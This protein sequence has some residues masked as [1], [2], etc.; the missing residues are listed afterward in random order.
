M[1]EKNIFQRVKTSYDL[2]R[3]SRSRIISVGCGGAR[4]FLEEMARCGVG[5]FVLID[6]DFVEEKNVGTQHV[7]LEDIGRP[8]VDCIADRIIQINP[9]ARVAVLKQPI[10][11]LDDG[12]FDPLI[13]PLLFEHD[14]PPPSA[15]EYVQYI[16]ERHS[17][18]ETIGPFWD[19]GDGILRRQP[20]VTLL[21]GM[22]DNFYAQARTHRLSLQYGLPSLCCQLYR[23]GQA[24]EVTFTY[25]GVSPACQ[26]C[27]LS[28][29][30][31]AYLENG[32]KNDVT[33]DGAPIFATTRINALCGKLTLAILHHGTNH[34]VWGEVL[35]RIGN[36]TLVQLRMHP[37]A[38]IKIFNQVFSDETHCFFDEAVWLPQEA[39]PDC[40][41]CHGTGN[42]L[43]ARGTFTDTRDFKHGRD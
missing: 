19:F 29:R 23:F 20:V 43:D 9:H 1:T 33:S 28:P 10:E 38:P 5:E 18:G 35:S 30:Y 24:G 21:C 11:E 36:R 41:E 37:D 17:E 4:S 13:S 7:F 34:P 6:W 26:R 40:P 25:P 14:P 32:Y 27:I 15:S 2:S 31:K 8:K 42:L 39:D 12:Q 22:T 16:P 3:M